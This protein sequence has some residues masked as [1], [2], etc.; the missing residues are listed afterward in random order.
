VTD[1]NQRLI[2]LDIVSDNDGVID[3]TIPDNPALVPPGYYMLFLIDSSGV[4]SMASWVQVGVSPSGDGSVDSMNTPG[5]SAQGV[6]VQS[7]H[8]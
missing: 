5:V 6:G 8:H 4:P 7:A 2:K 3:A 1:T